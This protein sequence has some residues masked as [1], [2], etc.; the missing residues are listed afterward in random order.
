LRAE[1]AASGAP[2]AGEDAMSA[3]APAADAVKDPEKARAVRFLR[4]VD[5]SIRGVQFDSAAWTAQWTS[6]EDMRAP[7]KAIVSLLFAV[8]P[9]VPPHPG[10]PL[11]LVR[12]LVLD[13]AY[14]LK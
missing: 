1:G 3:S 7:D 9:Q 4:A 11:A 12:E 13:P 2:A 8:P 14:E 10:E 5:R 6:A